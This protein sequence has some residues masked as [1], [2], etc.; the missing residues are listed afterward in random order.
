MDDVERRRRRLIQLGAVAFAAALI[1]G[2]LIAV[3]LSGGD[4]GGRIEG[5]AEAAALFAG[6]PQDGRLLGSRR[7]GVVM[8]EFADLQCPFCAQYAGDVLPELVRRYVR[9]GRLQ[10]ELKVIRILGPDSDPAAR[11][12]VAAGLQDKMW[13]FAEVFYGNQGVENTGY[14]DEEFIRDVAAGV[15]GIDADRLMR[16]LASPRVERMV[17]ADESRAHRLGVIGTPTFYLAR[18]GRQA[19]RL[20][21]KSLELD[22]FVTPLR[23]LTGRR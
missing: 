23:R 9:P 14:V 16:D 11:A 21:V 18:R 7:A 19:E 4:S 12:A 3:G 6:I 17:A 15:P 10:M 8:S 2:V 22:T 20:V 1:V 5:G 13:E